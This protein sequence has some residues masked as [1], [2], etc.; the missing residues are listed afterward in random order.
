ML[1]NQNAFSL[2]FIH[3]FSAPSLVRI[4]VCT[5]LDYCARGEQSGTDR[6]TVRVNPILS[7]NLRDRVKI[8]RQHG[9]VVGLQTMAS[10]V[11]RRIIDGTLETE[12]GTEAITLSSSSSSSSSVTVESVCGC[13]LAWLAMKY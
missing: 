4:G 6:R 11:W 13:G 10:F 12:S 5:F 2:K 3:P 8:T 7:P 9:A 1:I